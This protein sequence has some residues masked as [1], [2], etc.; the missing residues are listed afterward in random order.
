MLKV[1]ISYS[2]DD[3][4][5]VQKVAS[6]VKPHAEPMFW[7]QNQEPGEDAWR[8]IFGW[9]D[10][11]DC[12]IAVITDKVVNRGESVNQEIGYAKGKDKLV[13]PVVSPGVDKSR[14]G[15]LHGVTYIKFTDDDPSQAIDAIKEK[16]AAMDRSKREQQGWAVLAVAALVLL[17]IGG[18]G[19]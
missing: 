1:F 9:I 19:E 12:V 10:A 16:L 3:L 6:E 4:A 11:A 18:G 17:V 14:L 7:N 5:V 8:S 13:V 2:V 15:C